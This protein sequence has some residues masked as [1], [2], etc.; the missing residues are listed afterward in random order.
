MMGFDFLEFL[1]IER[2]NIISIVISCFFDFLFFKYSK[3]LSLKKL[4]LIKS[5]IMN[6]FKLVVSFQH[7]MKT[8][9][10]I[11]NITNEVARAYAERQLYKVRMLALYLRMTDNNN[12]LRNELLGAIREINSALNNRL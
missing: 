4:I 10:P 7:Y 9:Y 8:K 5:I 12:N 2:K 11:N 3:E 6:F 1:S